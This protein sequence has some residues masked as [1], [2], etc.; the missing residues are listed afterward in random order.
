VQIQIHQNH[1]SQGVR[2]GH[3]WEKH[4]T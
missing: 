1:G 3:N 2:W 4:F